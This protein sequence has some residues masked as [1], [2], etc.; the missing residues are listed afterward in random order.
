MD[1]EEQILVCLEIMMSDDMLPVGNW[2][3]A[4]E[5][6]EKRGLAAKWMGKYRITDD[7]VACL[8]EEHR[9]Q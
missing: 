2:R 4:L 5:E 9:C 8:E 6:C 7:G 1:L 3:P